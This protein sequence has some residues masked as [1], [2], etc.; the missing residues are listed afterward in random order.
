MTD[1][2]QKLKDQLAALPEQDRMEIADF[3]LSTVEGVGED[4]EFA[5]D[6]ELER[7]WR[8][9]ENGTAE[10]TPVEEVNARLR[11]KYS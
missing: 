9:I 11:E 5:W 2:A 3:L 10:G 7:R 1:A 6:E 4:A 8:E